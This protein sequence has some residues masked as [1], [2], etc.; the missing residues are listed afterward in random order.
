LAGTS[1]SAGTGAAT[2]IG[3][4]VEAPPWGG[5]GDGGAGAGASAAALAGGRLSACSSRHEPVE[6]AALRGTEGVGPVADLEEQG[7]PL[8]RLDVGDPHREDRLV[9]AERHLRLGAD[10]RRL[11]GHVGDQDDE[12]DAALDRQLQL[13]GIIH[14]RPDVARRDP[15][16]CAARLDEGGKLVGELAVVRAVAD[17]DV[18]GVAFKRIPCSGRN[19]IPI[20]RAWQWAPAI[21]PP[22]FQESWNLIAFVPGSQ[23]GIGSWRSQ[24]DEADY[25]PRAQHLRTRRTS[26]A[27]CPARARAASAASIRCQSRKV[28]MSTPRARAAVEPGRP[29]LRRCRAESAA[30]RSATS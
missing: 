28:T 10:I 7:E 22:S 9:G 19:A 15:D 18:A 25:R 30:I 29:A 11:V 26:R 16:P 1:G 23:E 4:D 13:L 3:A 20:L 8:R 17:E 6:I 24:D 21:T 14:A 12:G 2:A 5:G 27:G